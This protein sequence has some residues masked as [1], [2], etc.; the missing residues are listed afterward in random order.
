[1]VFAKHLLGIVIAV[2]AGS[3]VAHFCLSEDPFTQI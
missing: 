2:V 3:S 1:M